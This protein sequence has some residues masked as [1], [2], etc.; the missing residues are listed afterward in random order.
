MSQVMI[1]KF[2]GEIQ[3]TKESIHQLSSV[4]YHAFRYVVRVFWS[5]CGVGCIWGAVATGDQFLFYI[6]LFSGIWLL[7]NLELPAKHRADKIIKAGNGSL[8]HTR[9]CFEKEEIQISSKDYSKTISYKQLYALLEDNSYYYLFVNRNAG[10]VVD[11]KS[12]LPAQ[13][14]EFKAFLQEKSG[15]SF[16][17]AAPAWRSLPS[18]FRKGGNK[19]GKS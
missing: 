9:Y 5:F 19:F 11:K 17:N 13:P 14:E 15:L 7:L 16:R 6:L 4:Q 18:I 3:H 12:V 1:M 8:P 2:T 10:F